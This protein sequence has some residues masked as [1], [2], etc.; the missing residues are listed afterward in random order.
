LTVIVPLA[1]IPSVN[2]D[3][4]VLSGTLPVPVAGAVIAGDELE[5]AA[6][7]ELLDED[8]L[9]VEA[10]V[11]LDDPPLSEFSASCTAEVSCE[12]TRPRAV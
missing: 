6:A 3:V 2:S 12:L 8:V 7:L 10:L 11:L 5:L 4:L 1:R 9:L